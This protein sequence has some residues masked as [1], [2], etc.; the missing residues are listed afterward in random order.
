MIGIILLTYNRTDYAVSTIRGVVSNLTGGE[1][2][3]YVADDGS[4]PEHYVRVLAELS[5][6]NC[7]LL[8]SHSEKLSYGGSMN[9]ALDTLSSQVD[10][11]LLLEDDWELRTPLDLQPFVECLTEVPRAGVVRMGYLSSGIQGH[12]M[13][14]RGRGYWVLD[15]SQSR[16]HS[17]L[18]WAGHPCLVKSSY[19]RT[20]GRWPVGLQPG[21]TELAMA[22]QYRVGRGVDILWPSEFGIHGPWHHIGE[23]QSYIYHGQ[24]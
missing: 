16:H 12:L 7:R 6:R 14:H 10:I 9:R 8:G 3:W 2:G 18:A 22:H 20:H 11:Y 17:V 23:R 13:I 15:D 19:F 21:D 5:T 4:Q 1:F 24:L